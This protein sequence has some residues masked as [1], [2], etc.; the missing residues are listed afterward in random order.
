[1]IEWRDVVGYEGLYEVSGEGQVR[2]R[3]RNTTSGKVLK[4]SFG[5]C[6]NNDGTRYGAVG[7]YREGKATTT[8]V[9]QIVAKAF[10]GPC[11]DGL[12][13]RHLDGDYKNNHYTNLKYGTRQENAHDTIAHGR[14]G[15]G[16]KKKTHCA[17]GHPFDDENTRITK[18]GSRSCK[19]CN[20]EWVRQRRAKQKE[21]SA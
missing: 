7:L 17:K 2:S 14:W 5:K 8:R 21:A 10:I 18:S 13:V 9:H 12:E 4:I 19:E 6:N 3:P 20:R 11:P 16:Q 15:M 1:M